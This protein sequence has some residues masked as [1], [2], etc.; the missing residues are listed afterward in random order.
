LE[1]AGP[2]GAKFESHYVRLTP[3]SSGQSSPQSGTG[4]AGSASDAADLEEGLPPGGRG[5]N[6][7]RRLAQNF[8][9]IMCF[10][11]SGRGC[12]APLKEVMGTDSNAS[13]HHIPPVGAVQPPVPCRAAKKSTMPWHFCHMQHRTKSCGCRNGMSLVWMMERRLMPWCVTARQSISAAICRHL[14]GT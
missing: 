13:R 8:S 12:E 2:A 9:S 11:T 6:E 10:P 4:A 3:S 14:S 5:L 7:A 1:A